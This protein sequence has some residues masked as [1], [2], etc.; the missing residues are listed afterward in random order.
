MKP[1]L[2]MCVLLV[3][4]LPANTRGQAIAN[5][6]FEQGVDPNANG[7]NNLGLVAVDTT[8]I[9]G[10]TVSLGSVDYIGTRWQ[11]G[12]GERSVDL[13]GVTSGTL[14]QWV[15]GFAP[16]DAYRLSFLISGNPEA[17]AST[18]TLRVGIGGQSA[19]FT[20]DTGGFDAVNMGWRAES[21]DFLASSS[22][23]EFSFTGLDNHPYGVALDDVFLT[24]LGVLP[25]VSANDSSSLALF[26]TVLA[27]F[28]MIRGPRRSVDRRS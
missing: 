17:G 5:G 1:N 10:W 13:S 8:S 6:S 28:V 11:A 12:E 4:V 25:A 15:D 18:K 26:G 3:A 24:R 21:L 20:F 19:D 9:D 2:R 23:L 16:G 14:S 22:S 27:G 7:G